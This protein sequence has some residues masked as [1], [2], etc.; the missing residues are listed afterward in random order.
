M[1]MRWPEL[2]REN[3]VWTRWWW[4]GSAVDEAGITRELETMNAA[5]IGGVEITS[6]YGVKGQEHRSVSYLSERWLELLA[7][8]CREARRL[9]MGVD[10]PPGCGWRCGGPDTDDKYAARRFAVAEGDG[11]AASSPGVD[12]EIGFESVKR[13]GPGGSGRAIDMFDAE[14]VGRYME[15]FTQAITHAIPTG[16]IR[17]QFHDSW[18]YGADWSRELPA[19]FRSRRGYDLL[20]YASALSDDIPGELDDDTARRVRHDYRVT[21]EEMLLENFVGQWNGICH[22]EG[23]L[24]R[25]QAHGSPGNLLDIYAAVDIPE[26]EIYRDK[27]SPFINKFASSAGHVAGRR[28]IS[29]ES[30]TWLSDHFQSDLGKIKRYSDF[31]FLSGINHIL[32]HGTAYSAEDAVWPGWLF[33]A[34]SQVN[35]RNP[36][37]RD[38]PVINAYIG[39]CQSLLQD[40]QPDNDVLLYWP[41]TDIFMGSPGR[42]ITFHIDGDRWTAGPALQDAARQLWEAGFLFDYVSDRQIQECIAEKGDVLTS[43]QSRYRAIVVP[44]CRYMP[45]ATATALAGLAESGVRIVC[46]SDS[47]PSWDVPGLSQLPSR[48]ETLWES[49][50]RLLDMP[51][52]MCSEDLSTTLSGS[53]LQPEAF[54]IETAVR[55]VRRR[56]P[57]GTTLYFLANRSETP[58]DGTITPCRDAPHCVRLDPWD[59]AI[60]VLQ[61]AD[62]GGYRVQLAPWQSAFVLLSDTPETDPVAPW[63]YLPTGDAPAIDIAGDWSI[64]FVAGGPVCPPSLTADELKPI[65]E[66]GDPDLERFA[67]TVRYEASFGLPGGEEAATCVLE[68]GEV[69]GSARVIVNDTELGTRVMPPYRIAVPDDVLRSRNTLVVEVTTLAANRIRDLDRRGI[70]WRI[71]HDIN[72]IRLGGKPFD[73]SEWPI[74]REG[75]LG[76]VTLQ[77]YC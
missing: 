27:V 52:F 18:E 34:S 62:G 57:D 74:R 12:P 63:Q 73:A 37:W 28:L 2:A 46:L 59:G 64:S 49:V 4:L 11:T 66:M 17:T 55:C 20:K 69:S 5:G 16:S 6:I 70:E 53:G 39:R 56:R 76:P 23:M 44:P 50:S 68:L 36:I 25:N 7:H 33:Y 9:D 10:L 32:Y 48:R 71:F 45:A 19:F 51:A 13:A 24:T 38:L 29:S 54:Q 77:R 58:F 26:T 72:F 30:F 14:A 61:A 15:R 65:S 8:A 67:G 41:L 21:L 1:S 40:G 47:E 3:K 75:L 43:G 31:L 35:S 60:G 22:A 42:K